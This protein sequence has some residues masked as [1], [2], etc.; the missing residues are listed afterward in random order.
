MHGSLVHIEKK[1]DVQQAKFALT[2][3]ATNMN[4]LIYTCSSC[5]HQ[6]TRPEVS[7]TC[8]KVSQ[9]N[10]SSFS[11]LR[12]SHGLSNLIST[13]HKQNVFGCS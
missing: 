13:V 4:E 7:K 5:R 3:N 9:H 12:E 11:T 2:K 10:L 1:F 8:W 6:Q